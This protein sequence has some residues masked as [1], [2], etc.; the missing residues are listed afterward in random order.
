MIK[1]FK[2]GGLLLAVALLSTGTAYA[3]PADNPSGVQIAQQNVACTGVVKDASGETVIGA[4]VVVKGTTNGTVTD[5]D[6]RFTLSGVKQGATLVISFIGFQTQE[7]VWNGRPLSVTMKDDAQALEEVVVTAYG[8][9]QL[10]TKVTNSIAKVKDE[11]LKQGLYSNPAQ[12]LSGAVSGLRVIQSSGD[13]GAAPTIIL[14]GGTDFSGSGSPLY[15]IDGQVRESMSD[16]NPNDIESMEVMKDA[17]AT[18]IYGARANNGV[19]LITTKKGKSG[20]A[21][22]N[23]SAKLGL[24]HFH[25]SYTWLNGEQYLTYVRNAYYRAYTGRV[26]D[27]NGRVLKEALTNPDGTAVTGYSSL[28]THGSCTLRNRQPIL[29]SRRCNTSGW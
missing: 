7:V 9:R 13:P 14:R 15:V 22:V 12:A 23:F 29:C 27:A 3:I 4:S 17:G 16:I 8:G 26:T 18:A 2:S 19:V 5:L 24:N 28:Y 25:D 6:G 11:V 10:R 20:R 21:E 1:Q